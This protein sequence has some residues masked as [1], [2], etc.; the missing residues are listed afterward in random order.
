MDDVMPASDD[1]S[2]SSDDD[3]GPRQPAGSGS[4]KIATPELTEVIGGIDPAHPD[5]VPGSWVIIDGLVSAPEHNGASAVVFGFVAAT[6]RFRVFLADQLFGMRPEHKALNIRPQNINLD[7]SRLSNP[8]C[9]SESASLLPRYPY[10]VLIDLTNC[11]HAA[12]LCGAASP[13]SAARSLAITA[14]RR[15]RCRLRRVQQHR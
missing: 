11:M 1:M 12:T 15:S 2:T 5:I 10:P 4:G 14:T 9:G 8:E 3:A 13:G 7:H 6:G